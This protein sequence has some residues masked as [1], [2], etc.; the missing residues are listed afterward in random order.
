MAGAPDRQELLTALTTEH[1][2]LQGARSQTMSESSARASIYIL[3]VSSALVALGFIGQVSEVGDV[4]DVFALVA[5]PT[6]YL[7][8][9]ATFVRLIE[10]SAEDFRYGL[11]INRIRNYYKQVAGDQAKLFLLSG[12]DDGEGVFANM[13]VPAE[14]RPQYFSFAAVVAVINSV[15]GGSAAAI[16]IGAFADASLAPAAGVGGVVAVISLVVLLRFAARL[17]EARAIQDEV[18]FP[19]P[20]SAAPE[21]GAP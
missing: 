6:L 5:L 11:A 17:L 19:S 9:L 16:A 13:S 20:R 8:G 15:V 1:F 4:F 3:S 14:G 21:E 18:L 2:T 10:C 7:L 12:H